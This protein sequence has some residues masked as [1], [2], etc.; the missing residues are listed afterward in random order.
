[1]RSEK[2]ESDN[3]LCSVIV[4]ITGI[5]IYEFKIKDISHKGTCFIVKEDSTFLRH[6]QIGQQVEIRYHK[7]DG[8]VFMSLYRAE[9]RHITKKIKGR[10]K[11]HFEIGVKIITNLPIQ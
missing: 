2:R 6:L 10:F 5:P 7:S 8:S 11:G 4:R 3:A 1:M 9:I